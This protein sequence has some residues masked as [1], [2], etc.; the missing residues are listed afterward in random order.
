MNT[1]GCRAD[2]DRQRTSADDVRSIRGAGDSEVAGEV[3]G[4]GVSMAVIV[5]QMASREEF[6]AST[7]EGA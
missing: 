4:D 1:S 6:I 5:Q 3:S 7:V 2:R